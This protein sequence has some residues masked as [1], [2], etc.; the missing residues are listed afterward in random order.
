MSHRVKDIMGAGGIVK[1]VEFHGSMVKV[2][3]DYRGYGY[4]HVQDMLAALTGSFE[5]VTYV[6]LQQAVG[7]EH[8]VAVSDTH[9]FFYTDLKGVEYI[10]HKYRKG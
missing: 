6:E 2:I 10:E 4:F 7:T 3:E 1:I 9:R 5:G 8:V